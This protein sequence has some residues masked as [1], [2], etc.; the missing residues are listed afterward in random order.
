[1]YRKSKDNPSEVIMGGGDGRSIYRDKEGN[2]HVEL[3]SFGDHETEDLL[4]VR[5]L[6]KTETKPQTEEG[7]EKT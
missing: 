3:V 4:E 5:E 1:L 2:I 7:E 6:A